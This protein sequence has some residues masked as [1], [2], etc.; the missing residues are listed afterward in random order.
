MKKFKGD[1]KLEWVC[2]HG[3]SHTVGIPHEL[4]KMVVDGHIDVDTAFSHI[5]D[6]C[7]IDRKDVLDD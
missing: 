6:G 5:C 7:C 1:G 2:K 3:E 4:M